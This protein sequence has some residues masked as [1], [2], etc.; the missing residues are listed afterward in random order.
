MRLWVARAGVARPRHLRPG[1]DH[2]SHGARH[3]RDARHHTAEGWPLGPS[4][5]SACAAWRA[6][7]SGPGWTGPALWPGGGRAGGQGDLPHQQPALR[8]PARLPRLGG[9][10]ECNPMSSTPDAR[11]RSLEFRTTGMPFGR[12]QNDVADHALRSARP[13]QEP[14]PAGAEKRHWARPGQLTPQS[15]PQCTPRVP[16]VAEML[17]S[18]TKR[19]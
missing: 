5:R 9:A 14:E 12:R 11:P 6:S 15:A 10:A 4:A 8:H 2:A 18:R 13:R 17:N 7:Y 19:P 16:Q 3:D 1:A